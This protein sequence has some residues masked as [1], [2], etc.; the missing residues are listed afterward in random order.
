M[1][2]ALPKTLNFGLYQYNAKYI[3]IITVDEMAL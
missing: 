2:R 3:I 1:L